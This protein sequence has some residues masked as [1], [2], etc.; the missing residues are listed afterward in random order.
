ME[1]IV[2]LLREHA[3]DSYADFQSRLIPNVPRASILGVRTPVLRKLAAQLIREGKAEAF[4]KELP[5]TWFEENQLHGFLISQEKEFSK[6]LSQLDVFLPYMD[7]W[8]T[9]DQI[10]PKIFRRHRPELL[11]EIARWLQSGHP[12]TVRFAIGM[13]ITHFLEEDFCPDYLRMAVIPSEEYYVNMEIAWYLATA[14]AK[15]WDAAIVLLENREL[16]RWVHNRTIQK[17]RESRRI[18]QEQKAYLQTLRWK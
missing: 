7:N 8:A 5:H 2:H 14:L 6:C 3:E 10:S 12:Y 13:L 9:V 17:A 4:L 15:Q 11:P 1:E 18:S 16:S